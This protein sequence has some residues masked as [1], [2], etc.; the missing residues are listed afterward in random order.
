MCEVPLHLKMRASHD[1]HRHWYFMIYKCLI[2]DLPNVLYTM[3]GGKGHKFK[4]TFLRPLI[5][6]NITPQGY[7][8]T[9]ELFFLKMHWTKSYYKIIL[10]HVDAICLVQNPRPF[11]WNGSMIIRIFKIHDMDLMT[12]WL[13]ILIFCKGYKFEVFVQIFISCFERMNKFFLF[14]LKWTNQCLL[15]IEK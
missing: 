8:I 7:Y 10:V 13:S 2:H 1:L 3:E 12:I 11:I 15:I 6:R 14:P 5:L 9:Q 4:Y